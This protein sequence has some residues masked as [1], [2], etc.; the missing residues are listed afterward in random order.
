MSL[1]L[2]C[3]CEAVSIVEEN[4]QHQQQLNYKKVINN[5]NCEK[6]KKGSVLLIFFIKK[7]IL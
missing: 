1:S 6:N 4:Q 7:T 2:Q 5:A 3:L